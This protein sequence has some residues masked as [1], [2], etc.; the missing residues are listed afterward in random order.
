MMGFNLSTSPTKT[1]THLFIVFNFLKWYSCTTKTI[2]IAFFVLF[3]FGLF[4]VSLS[5]VY[6]IPSFTIFLCVLLMSF[7]DECFHT[8]TYTLAVRTVGTIGLSPISRHVKK[9]MHQ[10]SNFTPIVLEK[11]PVIVEALKNHCEYSQIFRSAACEL[12]L[13]AA[14]LRNGVFDRKR[15]C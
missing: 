13:A 5:Q 11:I 12:G 7:S 10:K 3:P 9:E 6:L 1:E 15:Q 8:Y 14:L 4:F 2:A